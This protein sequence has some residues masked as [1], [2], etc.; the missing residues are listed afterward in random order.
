MTMTTEKYEVWSLEEGDTV[1][2]NGE[3]YFVQVIEPASPTTS[4]LWLV[5]DEGFQHSVEVE[6]S[7]TVRVVCDA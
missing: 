2:M 6:D 1:V 4:R 5:D 7:S 3:T